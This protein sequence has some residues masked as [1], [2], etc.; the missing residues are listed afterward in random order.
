[1]AE[2]IGKEKIETHKQLKKAIDEAE[3]S[4]YE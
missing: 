2:R 1:M 4:M 3:P